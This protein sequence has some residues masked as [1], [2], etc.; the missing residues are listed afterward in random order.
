VISCRWDAT[1]RTVTFREWGRGPAAPP[2]MVD[3]NRLEGWLLGID[4]VRKALLKAGGIP[5]GSLV[6]TPVKADD[7]YRGLLEGG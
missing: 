4:E 6:R 5:G 3:W 2:T 7:D 1:P